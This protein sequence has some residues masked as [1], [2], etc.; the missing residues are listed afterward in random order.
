MLRCGRNWQPTFV[1]RVIE[2]F[3]T[4]TRV[5][6]VNTDAGFGYMKG[7]GNPSGNQSLAM[8]LVG[9]ELAANLGLFVPDFA[10]V[11]LQEIEV[12]MEGGGNLAFGP[13]FISRQ[14]RCIPSDG[15]LE[16][17][18]R[19]AN[20]DDLAL[21]VMLDTW[22]RNLDRCPPADYLDPTPRRDNLCFSPDGRK[23]K[24]MVIDHSH[25]FVEEQLELG[26]EEAGF[27]EDDRIYGYFPEFEQY[28]SE[29]SLR[30]AAQAVTAIDAATVAEIVASVPQAWGPTGA[31]RDLWVDRIVARQARVPALVTDTI[32]PQ[33]KFDV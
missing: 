2:I 30:K 13:A 22:I 14:C 20:S 17:V 33:A 29:S 26:L 31:I 27:V 19:L 24:L 4:S 10:V 5:A 1:D 25:C 3:P 18:S 7:M 9:S 21:L 6:L 23:L 16:L 8:E 15:T 32:L 12:P 11:D 28:I